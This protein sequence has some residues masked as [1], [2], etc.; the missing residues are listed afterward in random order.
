MACVWNLQAFA[1]I[2]P[3]QLHHYISDNKY[4]IKAE[5]Q[6]FYWAMEYHTAWIQ[7]ENKS[8]LDIIFHALG[9]SSDK[10]LQ[11]QDYNYSLVESFRNN[12]ISLRNKADSLEAEMQITE[13]AIH[14]YCN[15]AY[16]NNKP[17]L[18]YNGLRLYTGLS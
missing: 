13:T 11:Q 16:G 17:A 14:F 7:H 8:N 10:G 15:I 5:V 18:G 2:T 3:D 4:G 9:T 6:M 12:T 1:E